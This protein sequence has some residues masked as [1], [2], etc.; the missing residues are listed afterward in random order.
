M[1]P[2]VSK[3]SEDSQGVKEPSVV[4]EKLV[5]EGITKYNVDNNDEKGKLS[6]D[7]IKKN[8]EDAGKKNKDV[9]DDDEDEEKRQSNDKEEKT[10][11]GRQ[12]APEDDNDFDPTEI[13]ESSHSE[14]EDVDKSAEEGKDPLE[15]GKSEISESDDESNQTSEEETLSDRSKDV[16]AEK[17]NT[18]GKEDV[19][20]SSRKD[21]EGGDVSEKRVEKESQDSNESKV[22]SKE[23]DVKRTEAGEEEKDVE[24]KTIDDGKPNAG[25]EK[26]DLAASLVDVENADKGDTQEETSPDSQR[27][28]DSQ[29]RPDT[30]SDTL[31][32]ESAQ[33]EDPVASEKG[34]FNDV[35]TQLQAS[36]ET[37]ADKEVDTSKSDDRS[38]KESFKQTSELDDSGVGEEDGKAIG[39]GFD[40]FIESSRVE[41]Q[42]SG[43]AT[44]TPKLTTNPTTAFLEG[45]VS[46]SHF[47]TAN[48]DSS[49]ADDHGAVTTEDDGDNK[50]PE[51][52][53]AETIIEEGSTIII[54]RN[55]D[56]V[57]AI[58]PEAHVSVQSQSSSPSLNSQQVNPTAIRKILEPPESPGMK[59][60]Q[61]SSDSG[62]EHA[63]SHRNNVS[64]SGTQTSNSQPEIDDLS[65]DRNLISEAYQNSEFNSRKV[66]SVKQPQSASQK[67]LQQ[68]PPTTEKQQLPSEEKKQQHITV[69]PTSIQEHHLTSDTELRSKVSDINTE[70]AAESVEV[71]DASKSS[72]SSEGQPVTAQSEEKIRDNVPNSDQKP[73]EPAG[74]REVFCCVKLCCHNTQ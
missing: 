27:T 32:P 42:E 58:L 24:N 14:S 46:K 38:P 47:Q 34:T 22:S 23:V 65:A 20:K 18:G 11:N 44:E 62:N 66:L 69:E 64:L 25:E 30:P 52:E 15:T 9:N 59:E 49:Q 1:E 21:L 13:N 53:G 71:V 51:G 74:D 12:N 10:S 2:E 41:P 29:V 3:K 70:A 16:R 28:I 67:Q 48:I 45:E 5:D 54:D 60:E 73:D 26:E 17:A 57:T 50:L 55:G 8:I 56:L 37:G 68:S 7:D 43:T 72:V 35:E 19:E 33:G 40:S 63:Q 31:S 36:V 6:E 61:S 39:H 4:R